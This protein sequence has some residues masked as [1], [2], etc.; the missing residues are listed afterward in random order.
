MH[1][2]NLSVLL[3]E[4]DDD[5]AE[6]VTRTLRRNR[7]AGT[8]ARLHDGESALAYLRR[9]DAYAD[10]PRPDIVLLD[11]KLPKL[12]GYDVLKAIKGD[13]VLR[14]IPVIILTTSDAEADRSRAY[15][16]NA[17]SYIVK[18]V[19]FDRFRK[20]VE[21]LSLYWGVWSQPPHG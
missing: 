13:D 10:R 21:D 9:E 20:M 19:N 11:L 12:D 5:H 8:I 1:G 6:L 17:N 2:T 18:P 15:A 3:V 7:L 16:Y 14:M 4:D